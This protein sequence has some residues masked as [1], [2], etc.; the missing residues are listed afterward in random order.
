[1]VVKRAASVIL[2]SEVNAMT[3]SQQPGFKTE[4]NRIWLP[5]E[6]GDM[7]AEVLFPA[8]GAN[9]VNITHTFVDDSLRGRG[10]AGKLMEAAVAELRR[11]GKKT[12][13]TCPYAVQW[14]PRHPEFS[15]IL[16]K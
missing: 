1:M 9:I 13:L 7:L 11:Q 4:P 10:I 12:K 3:D 14:F 16:Y 5:D 15:D 6:K 8:E 2:S